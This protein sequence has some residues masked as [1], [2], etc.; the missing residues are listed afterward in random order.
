MD[1]VCATGHFFDKGSRSIAAAEVQEPPKEPQKPDN[2]IIGEV[3]GQQKEQNDEVG[4]QLAKPESFDPS[5]VY[6]TE[7][8]EVEN[9]V[10]VGPLRS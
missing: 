9:G 2:D 10:F 4:Q 6:G 5:R 3:R 8:F 7:H 1:D